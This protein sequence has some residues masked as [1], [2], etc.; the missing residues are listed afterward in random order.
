MSRLDRYGDAP[1]RAEVVAGN[2]MSDPGRSPPSDE[3]VDTAKSR[4]IIRTGLPTAG[5]IRLG[6]ILAVSDLVNRDLVGSNFGI[7]GYK[8]VRAPIAIVGWH[9]RDPPDGYDEESGDRNHQ[10]SKTAP[11]EPHGYHHQ[12]EVE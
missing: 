5:I 4:Q 11:K 10:P 9:E 3:D 6:A 7:G 2:G 8:V 1:L 12:D